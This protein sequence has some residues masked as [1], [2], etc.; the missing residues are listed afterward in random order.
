M[1]GG[2]EK[3]GVRDNKGGM[4]TTECMKGPFF[5]LVFL[6]M[7]MKRQCSKGKLLL[8]EREL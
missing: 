2:E 7:M 5:N 3:K 6:M 1:G 4:A 8:I